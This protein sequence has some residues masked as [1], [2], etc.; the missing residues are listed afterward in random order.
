MALCND[1]ATRIVIKIIKIDDKASFFWTLEM[2]C[3]STTSM[4]IRH[5]ALI[6]LTSKPQVAFQKRNQNKSLVKLNG[7]I[8]LI[9]LGS[10]CSRKRYQY[11]SFN[12]KE[13]K[14]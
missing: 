14:T 11:Q 7:P 5:G 4:P 2:A 6:A 3:H 9:N 13:N 10:T 1:M 12:R 8:K